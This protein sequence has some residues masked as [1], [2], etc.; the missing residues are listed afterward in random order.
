MFSVIQ[1][2]MYSVLI[3]CVCVLSDYMTA[4][5]AVIKKSKPAISVS[6][7]ISLTH[8]HTHTPCA[9][10][11][12]EVEKKKQKMNKVKYWHF[13]PE[14]VSFFPRL[15]L[16]CQSQPSVSPCM[17]KRVDSAF[18]RA[19]YLVPPFSVLHAQNQCIELCNRSTVQKEF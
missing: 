10:V 6:L 9:D 1:W 19:C 18:L 14:Y 8:S 16:P 4:S 3:T 12:R 15:S 5:E 17:Q 11:R 13:C 7:F 2:Q